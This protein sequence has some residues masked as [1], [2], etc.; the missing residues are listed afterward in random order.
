MIFPSPGVLK[1][2]QIVE[3]FFK[4]R[5]LESKMEITIE[6]CLG[7]HI[8]DQLLHHIGNDIFNSSADHYAN[9]QIEESDYL[10]LLLGMTA[11]MYIDFRLKTYGKRYTEIKANKNVPSTR[12]F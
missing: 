2:I 11:K 10:T 8:T 12:H 6:E 9:H 7:T 3:S 5:M 4:L 1:I